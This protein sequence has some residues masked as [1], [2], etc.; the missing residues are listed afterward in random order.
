M[1]SGFI[2]AIITEVGLAYLPFEDSLAES[3]LSPLRA[4]EIE[5]LQV[6]VGKL[7]NMTCTHCHVDAGPHGEKNMARAT[8]DQVLDFLRS[9]QGLEIDI[10]GGAPELN[11]H[12]RYLVEES[13]PHARAVLVRTN[14]TVLFEP[15]Q[16][17]L[18]WPGKRDQ[19]NDCG[20]DEDPPDHSTDGG[21]SVSK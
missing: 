3:G 6:N 9:N 14:L 19:P 16:E 20:D 17:E 8:V 21:P 18:V 2:T 13:R 12:F 5:V 10:T 7:C 15:G 1:P 11:P 4:F